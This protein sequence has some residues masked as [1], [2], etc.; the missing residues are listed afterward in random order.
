MAGEKTEKAT[1]KKKRDA[2]KEGN[3][4][5]SIEINNTMSIFSSLLMLSAFWLTMSRKLQEMFGYI[6]TAGFSIYGAMDTDSILS[7]FK[8][9]GSVFFSIT[10]PFMVI[11]M[12]VGIVSNFV[13]VGV[14]FTPKSVMPKFERISMAGGFKKI[15]SMNTFNN[16][17]KTLLKTGVVLI[18]AWNSMIPLIEDVSNSANR[19]LP[20]V[21]EKN[22]SNMLSLALKLLIGMVTI[23]VLDYAFQWFNHEKKLKMSKQEVK[24]EYKNTEGNPEV[25]SKIKSLQRQMAQTRMMQDVPGADVVIANPTHF[26]VAL[27]YDS[28]KN[29]APVV[30]AKGADLIALRIKEIAKENK[31]E[32]VE[33][34][35]VARALFAASEIGD[36]VPYE[37]FNAVAE[38]LAYIYSKKRGKKN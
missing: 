23:S 15:F 31:V 28:K 35:E 8:Y 18:I 25:K 26:A 2:R 38:I 16:F 12:T 1:P 19:S 4:F 30:V 29:K 11:L 36:E 20:S 3:V 13:Q 32:I 9:C 37:L 7:L 10:G 17:L 34:K 21:L 14:L 5:K 6:F 27:K 22:A 24:D 33:N